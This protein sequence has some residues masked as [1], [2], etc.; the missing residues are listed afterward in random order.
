MTIILCIKVEGRPASRIKRANAATARRS[1]LYPTPLAMTPFHQATKRL[2]SSCLSDL[3]KLASRPN[4]TA[5]DANIVRRDVGP[6]GV[7]QVVADDCQLAGRWSERDPFN[8]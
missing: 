8:Q 6:T 5:G 2:L 1:A 3:I 7:S 4:D